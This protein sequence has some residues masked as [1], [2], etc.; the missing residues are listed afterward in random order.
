VLDE[1]AHLVEMRSEA[2]RLTDDFL[3]SPYDKL[4][5]VTFLWTDHVRMARLAGGAILAKRAPRGELGT[6]AHGGV[7]W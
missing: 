1:V 4:I 2:E 3:P 5:G 7:K 6:E